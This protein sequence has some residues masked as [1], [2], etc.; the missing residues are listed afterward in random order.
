MS[1][2]KKLVTEWI[3]DL[4]LFPTSHPAV[5]LR[6]ILYFL[7]GNLKA[8]KRQAEI[9]KLQANVYVCRV[10]GK[11]VLLKE[12]RERQRDRKRERR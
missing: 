4:F 2:W 12:R 9:L 5:C 3:Q 11:G 8:S 1:I 7:L 10:E 6:L